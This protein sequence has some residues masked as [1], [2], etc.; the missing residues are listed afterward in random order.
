M[1]FSGTVGDLGSRP[2]EG[3]RFFNVYEGIGTEEDL[4]EFALRDCKE[5]GYE[6]MSLTIGKG[7]GGKMKC[8]VYVSSKRGII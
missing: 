4:R 7:D 1:N 2:F 6:V 5:K 8:E 3:L